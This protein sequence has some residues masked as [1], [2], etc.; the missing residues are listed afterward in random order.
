MKMIKKIV[1]IGDLLRC[2]NGNVG[3]ADR[4]L[5]W[6]YYLLKEQIFQATG[7]MPEVYYTNNDRKFNLY[8][9][10]ELCNY[11]VSMNN[12]INIA[13]GHYTNEAREYVKECFEDTLVI[14]QVG[15]ALLQVLDNLNIPYIDIYVS[16]FKFLEDIHLAFRTNIKEIREKLVKYTYRENNLY[17]YANYIKSYYW[18]ERKKIQN[19]EHNSLLLLGQTDVDL[20]LIKDNRLV[21]L[22]DYT[23]KIKDLCT[24]YNKVYY[25]PHPYAKKDN[26]NEIFIRSIENVSVINTNFYRLMSEENII[27]TA[28]LSS[29]TLTESKY[30]GKESIYIS[31]KFVNYCFDKKAEKEDFILIEDEYYSPTFW[32]DIL[33]PLFNTIKCNNFNFNNNTNRL[34]ESLHIFWDYEIGNQQIKPQNKAAVVQQKT[35]ERIIIKEE[36]PSNK[37]I[38]SSDISVIVQGAIIKNETE[39]TLKSIRKKLPNAEIILSTWQ[40]S[41]ILD[42]D[43]DILVLNEDP[44]ANSLLPVAENIDNVNRQIISTKNGLKRATRKYA[45]KLRT[46]CK[47]SGLG[48][49]NCFNKIKTNNLKREKAYNY[50]KER[51]I[52]DSI[53]TRDPRG[54]ASEKLNLCF[55]PSDIWQFGLTEDLMNLFNIPLQTKFISQINNVSYQYRVPEQYILTAF[56]EKQGLKIPLDYMY[57]NEEYTCSLTYRILLNNFFIL[58]NE[59]SGITLP[60]TFPSRKNDNRL[61]S[62]ILTTNIY[63]SLYK[64]LY[65]KTFKFPIRYRYSTILECLGINKYLNEFKEIIKPFENLIKIPYYLFKILFKIILNGYKLLIWWRK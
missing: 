1:F 53:F 40:G 55:H 16:A 10:Y 50:F 6:E 11:E 59:D 24:Q 45:L 64:A 37:K 34:R 23:D 26:K 35:L 46:D 20:S 62:A 58:N 52:I 15:G 25:K 39:K 43:Y 7:I 49:I 3:F 51:V 57:H 28:A 21:L 22:S 61:Y 63:F 19:I 32:S 56:L 27:A 13:C 12:W 17:I 47:I 4:S 29:G 18:A 44:G 48:F 5:G 14:T 36:N 8:K 42:L 33:A 54:I 9:F 38:S 31:H 41:D 30:F 2:Q 65:D 60:K